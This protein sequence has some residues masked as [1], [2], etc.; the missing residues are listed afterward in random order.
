MSK[1]EVIEKVPVSLAE[2]KSEL[3]SIQKRDT[4]LGFRAGKTLEYVNSVAV[5]SK[6]AFA[7]LK[8]E[9]EALKVPRLKDEH[10]VKILD[11]MPKSV[12]ELNIILQ[13][14]VLTVTKENMGKIVKVIKDSSKK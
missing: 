3:Q 10:I 11:L 14:Y 4:E 12:N 8:A 2:L 1:P 7:K 6:T 5:L 9:I 13:G